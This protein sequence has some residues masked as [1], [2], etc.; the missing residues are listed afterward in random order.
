MYTQDLF[1]SSRNYRS[2]SVIDQRVNK[3]K[4]VKS[5][6]LA[7]AIGLGFFLLPST[8]RASCGDYLMPGKGHDAF[9]PI[10]GE[11]HSPS[12]AP[13]HGPHCSKGSDQLPVAPTTVLTPIRDQWL[14]GLSSLVLGESGSR[15]LA[16]PENTGHF[17]HI[18]FRLER[19]PRV[20]SL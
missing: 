12:K 7:L 11:P 20:L 4:A 1:A 14:V 17:V 15:A 5:A 13:C 19:P 2:V 10:K 6:G 18:P 8:A 9:S 3:L 16:I